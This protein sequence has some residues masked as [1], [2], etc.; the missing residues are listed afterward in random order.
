MSTEPV[1]T[2]PAI[3]LQCSKAKTEV[4]RLKTLI[5][6]HTHAEQRQAALDLWRDLMNKLDDL[7]QLVTTR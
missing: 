5:A 3:D 4:Y 6:S 2:L 7:Q 1:N